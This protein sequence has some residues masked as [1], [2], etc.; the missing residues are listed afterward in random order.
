MIEPNT[1][2]LGKVM[3]RIN[4]PFS[5]LGCVDVIKYT[6]WRLTKT[7]TKIPSCLSTGSSLGRGFGCWFSDIVSN[8]YHI[9]I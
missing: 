8:L 9:V 3:P 2:T 1:A 4:M 6:T 7:M 5:R